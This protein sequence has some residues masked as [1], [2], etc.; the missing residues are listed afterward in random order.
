MQSPPA[1][2]AL[3]LVLVSLLLAA[4]ARAVDVPFTKETLDNGLTVIYAPMGT[5]PVVHVRVL[6]HVG[7]RD[8]KPDRQGF[9]HLFEHMMFRGSQHVAPEQHMKLIGV[10]GGESNAFTSFDQ[11]TYVNTVPN[12]A[13]EMALY[14]EADRMASFKATDEIF[15]TERQ[16]VAEEWRMRYANQPLGPM[17][18]DLLST[19][20]TQHSYR[21][22]PIGDMD[23]LR[24]ARTSE[25][26]DFF[27]AYY[28]P[29]NACLVIAG[30]FDDAATRKWVRDYF[31]WIPRGPQPPRLARPEDAQAQTRRKTVEKPNV[32]LTN[33]QIGFKAPSYRSDEWFALSV[34]GDVLAS[35]RTGRLD[36]AL[37]TGES[38]KCV[39]VG[40]GGWQ[41][42]DPSLFQVSAVLQR[43]QSS[44]DVEKDV[45][46]VID[47][48]KADGVTA[49]EVAKVKAQNRQA[50]IRSR[51]TAEEVASQLAEEEVFGGD[52][53]RVNETMAKLQAVTPEQVQAAARKYLTPE[54]MTVLEYK[55]GDGPPP[56]TQAAK[57]EA[58]ATADVAPSTQPV[59]PRVTQFPPNYPTQPPMS[60]KVIQTVFEKGVE[61][62]VAGVPGIT[63]FTLT[64]KRLPLVNASLYVRAGSDAEPVG[65]E[66]VAEL[67]A[68]LMRRGSGGK[69]SLAFSDDLESRGISIEIADASDHTRLSIACTSDQLEYAVRQAGEVLAK[70]NF[71]DD[72]FAK[73]KEQSIDRLSQ[74]LT[75]PATIASRELQQAV[76]GNSPLGRIPTV[77]SLQS[78]TLDDVKAW[79]EKAYRL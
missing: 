60:D 58:T 79:Y 49:D 33:L 68:A 30:K 72:E 77:A 55:R 40:A 29:N 76:Y 61:S 17:T 23:Q 31:G 43:G 9:A 45:L 20:F 74:S 3:P 7:S 73:L 71:S 24:A 66:G 14:L 64:D 35:G 27:N 47:R 36:R 13:L 28:L 48:I 19:M 4:P 26:Q 15:K 75:S 34:L 38:P 2:F 57:A 22:T 10:V 69:E 18:Q 56:A 67:T 42:E 25:L 41:L 39:S 50:L 78:I 12:N 51:D 65:K 54:S 8:E 37:V 59:T 16:V 70:P 5:A 46:A 1:H 32:A 44:A 11:T 52:A 62:T 53:N 6:Y 21:W 63:V